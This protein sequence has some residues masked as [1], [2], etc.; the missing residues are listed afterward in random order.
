MEQQ[1]DK[2]GEV[3]RSNRIAMGYTQLELSR[4][5][6]MDLAIKI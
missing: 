1:K 2:I 3:V 6:N 5:A 4:L